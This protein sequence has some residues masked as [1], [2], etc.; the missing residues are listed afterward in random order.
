MAM[1]PSRLD[2]PRAAILPTAALGNNN[3]VLIARMAIDMPKR[4]MPVGQ[5]IAKQHSPRIP[6]TTGRLHRP[7]RRKQ[8]IKPF[9][10]VARELDQRFS[11]AP[12]D[13]ER[14]GV[15]GAWGASLCVTSLSPRERAGGEGEGS[16]RQPSAFEPN[17]SV[18]RPSVH[19]EAWREACVPLQPSEA[20]ERQPYNAQDY[21]LRGNATQRRAYAHP[22]PQSQDEREQQNTGNNKPSN[23][24]Q[25]GMQFRQAKHQ[26]QCTRYSQHQPGKSPT[27]RRRSSGHWLANSSAR[28]CD[29]RP[30][31]SR[32]PGCGDVLGLRRTDYLRIR[33]CS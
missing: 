29:R 14:V 11:L 1:S 3:R 25:A 31:E 17:H 9:V 28:G 22:R 8:R 4:I 13:G 16:V 5:K 23:P 33:L 15:R 12:S 18:L 2:P 6:V 27:P 26:D 32:I 24:C 19:G 7:S 30:H 10:L 21:Q 20:G